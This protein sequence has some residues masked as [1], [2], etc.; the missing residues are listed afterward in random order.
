[1]PS[2]SADHR[3]EL[4]YNVADKT[5]QQMVD[6]IPR[7]PD[8]TTFTKPSV[9]MQGGTIGKHARHVYD[10]FHLLFANLAKDPNAEWLVDFDARARNCP[11]ENAREVAIQNYRDIQTKLAQVRDQIPLNT[12]LTL[13][14]TVDP[15]DDTKVEFSSTFDRE[16]WYCC[17]HAIH[18]Y[19][20]VKA[21]CIENGLQV[22]HE[23]GTAPSTVQYE[24]RQEVSK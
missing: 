3:S 7:L 15:S 13:A 9:V 5:L 2:T 8:D 11:M 24:H 16:L 10:H 20:S 6:L 19:A 1:M 12:P 18:H 22:P 17:M 21:I 14:A 4:I 23:F